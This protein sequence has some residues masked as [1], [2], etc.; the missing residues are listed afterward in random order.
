MEKEWEELKSV[1]PEKIR[2]DGL[3]KFRDPAHA[4]AFARM[5]S[6]VFQTRYE[7]WCACD[8]HT[9]KIKVR[10]MEL[11]RQEYLADLNKQ[12]S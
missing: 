7:L 8:P 2:A 1:M 3:P 9:W 4:E 6:R 5:Y 12:D 10:D 11:V